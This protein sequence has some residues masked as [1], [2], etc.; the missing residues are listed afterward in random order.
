MFLFDEPDTH[1]NPKWRAKL[2]ETLNYITAT[3]I[4]ENG[5][6]THVRNQ[7]IVITTH[8]P[9]V[10]SDSFTKDVYRFQK[11]DGVISYENPEFKTY[12]ASISI[13]LEEIFEK[14]ESISEM[15]VKNLSE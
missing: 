5:K 8:S 15:A 3:S 2:I 4:N 6:I 12:G 1:F 13:I 11:K 9:F 7:E 14:E 10:I